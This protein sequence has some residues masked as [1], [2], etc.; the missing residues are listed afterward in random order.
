M[1]FILFSENIFQLQVI[2]EQS[3]RIHQPLILCRR[4]AGVHL[5]EVALQPAHGPVQEA[6]DGLVGVL[7]VGRFDDESDGRRRR[8]HGGL[9]PAWLRL[10]QRA[11]DEEEEEADGERPRAAG[12]AAARP[13][14]PI[15]VRR[16]PLLS[17]APALPEGERRTRASGV[18]RRPRATRAQGGPRCRFKGDFPVRQ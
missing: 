5:G 13:P 16:E 3:A 18:T 7:L 4:L 8:R 6:A 17:P 15:S 10:E 1:I 9:H 14:A 2:R 11:Q 12:V